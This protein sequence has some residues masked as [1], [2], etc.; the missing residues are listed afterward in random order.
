M[1]ESESNVEF[2]EKQGFCIPCSSMI[3][4]RAWG[5]K[6]CS[7][8]HSHAPPKE[9]V[10][11]SSLSSR[12]VWMGCVHLS[13]VADSVIWGGGGASPW[14]GGCGSPSPV[15]SGARALG[16]GRGGVSSACQQRAGGGQA[17][18]L[19][20]SWGLGVRLSLGSGLGLAS[21]TLTLWPPSLISCCARAW[22][23]G[24]VWHPGLACIKM[25]FFER[26]A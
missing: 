14:P 25:C 18:R 22:G 15:G 4:S 17:C 10:R 26:F 24:E 12:M 9:G 7:H 19:R 16:R 2:E 5:L 23:E 20:L 21:W 11:T 3:G 8:S 13:Y 6:W 1:W